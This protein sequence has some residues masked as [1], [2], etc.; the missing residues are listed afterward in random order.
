MES[1]YEHYL[2]F[3]GSMLENLPDQVPVTLR[4]MH[5]N[6]DPFKKPFL[7]ALA[8]LLERGVPSH[9]NALNASDLI[10]ILLEILDETSF[11]E[12][13]QPEDVV[14]SP[15]NISCIESLLNLP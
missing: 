2:D 5:S 11:T 1:S 12:V 7:E 6:H 3:V 13:D 8:D 4:C 15:V 10:H 9:F 14:G